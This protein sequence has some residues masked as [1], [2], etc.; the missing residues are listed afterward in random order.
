MLTPILTDAFRAAE[1][2]DSLHW[3]NPPARW[4]LDPRAGTLLVE[5]YGGTDFWQRTHYGFA[6]DSGHLL[7]TAVRGDF[8]LIARVSFEPRHQY[9]QA[10]LMV[11][12]SPTRWIKTAV[13]FEPDSPARLGAVVTADGYSDWSTQDVPRDVRAMAFRIRREGDD[14]L[15]ETGPDGRRW[16]Q[17]RLAHLAADPPGGEVACGLY[18]CS[19]QGPGY[20]AVFSEFQIESGR[21]G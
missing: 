17:I 11:R 5:S 1:L 4:S 7:H 8:V 2:P 10:G 20:V 14:Y 13:E 9:D 3:L 19:P 15:I 6:A 16:S 18:A 12:L 21:L